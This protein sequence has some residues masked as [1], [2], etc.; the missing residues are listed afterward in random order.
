MFC[1]SCGNEVAPQAVVCVKCGGPIGVGGGVPASGGLAKSRTAFILLGVFLG[2]LGVHNFY[3]GYSGRGIAQLL[4]TVLS[5]GFGALVSAV[6][7]I[8]EVCTVQVD[9]TGRPFAS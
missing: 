7:A 8:I 1:P 5:C 2:G 3:A 6:W 4:I 9:A